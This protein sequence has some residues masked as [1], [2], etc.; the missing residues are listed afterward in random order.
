M[1]IPCDLFCRSVCV[2]VRVC[3]LSPVQLCE[4]VDCTL[5]GS[6]GPGILQARILEWVA[7]SKKEEPLVKG[8]LTFAVAGRTLRRDMVTAL[9]LW[10][11]PCT[12]SLSASLALCCSQGCLSATSFLLSLTWPDCVSL[13]NTSLSFLP[14]VKPIPASKA[15]LSF[16]TWTV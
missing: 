15:N 7:I 8:K 3:T 14:P 5:P 12:L 6:F 2:C 1:V 16:N 9:A 11:S 4:P 13:P 10:P